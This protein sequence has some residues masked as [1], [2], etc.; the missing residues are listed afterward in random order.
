MTTE[1][2]PVI[3]WILPPGEVAKQRQVALTELARYG[4]TPAQ[5]KFF[6]P[7]LLRSIA[8]IWRKD[9]IEAA[10]YKFDWRKVDLFQQWLDK[11][12]AQHNPK[13]I[14]CNDVGVM[15]TFVDSEAQTAASF[16]GF[17]YRYRGI[18]VVIIDDLR[19]TYIEELSLDVAIELW[20]LRQDLSK[21]IRLGKGTQ[22]R[23]AAFKYDLV[24]SLEQ[25]ETALEALADVHTIGL[26]IETSG[27]WVSSLCLG[28]F[29]PDGSYVSYVWA[30][31]SAEQALDGFRWDVAQETAIWQQLAAF[32]GRKNQTVVCHNGSYD[33]SFLQRVGVTMGGGYVD[34][35][36]MWHAIWAQTKKSLAFCCSIM[37]DDASFWKDEV[38]ED[39]D[40]T[41]A[42]YAVPT[43][44][45]GLKH[46]FQYNALDVYYMVH[47]TMQ[48][49]KVLLDPKRG[50]AALNY[51]K[52]MLNQFGP[53]AYM[54]AIGLRLD[55]SRRMAL[56]DRLGDEAVAGLE[57]LL[58]I[59]GPKFNPSSTPQMRELFYDVLGDV[60]PVKRGPQSTDVKVMERMA[61]VSAMHAYMLGLVKGY[62][63]PVNNS[64]KY[65]DSFRIS[66]NGR[67][68]YS[69]N[70]SATWS[71]RYAGKSNLWNMGTNPQNV[72]KKMR[73][74]CIA[75]EGYVFLDADYG[76]SDLWFVAYEAEDE[77]L[78]ERLNS[79]I[80]IH[81]AHVED[82][83]GVPYEQ[84]VTWR[85]SDD[86][87]KKAFIEHPV[88]GVRQ[89][90]KKVVHGTNYVMMPNTMYATI[91]RPALVAAA[92]SAGH[93]GAAAW[94]NRELVEYCG[95]LQARYFGRY[96]GVFRARAKSIAKCRADGL[97][98]TAYGPR[99]HQFFSDP[100]T[101]HKTGRNLISFFGQAGTAGN[102]N[103]AVMRLYWQT[104]LLDQGVRLHLQVHD[105][106]VHGVPLDKLHLADK[107]YDNMHERCVIKGREFRVPVEADW[108]F[109]W[110]GKSIPYKRGQPEAE[111]RAALAT[112][113]EKS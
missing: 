66:E 53:A 102:I 20:I 63:Q 27:I 39:L 50:W 64:A 96:K 51:R 26:D 83:L 2:A 101:D 111:L 70:I 90:I 97:R 43:T 16:R 21:V 60:R 49:S 24:T 73:G 62:K 36:H 12:I 11:Q 98:A 113:K 35:Q 3:F 94:G 19:K 69:L 92:L 6:Q 80:D 109:V 91:G 17:V 37:L 8:E 103:E 86:P 7:R 89:I 100:Y 65:G 29:K 82:L 42:K 38:K 28:G 85:K 77:V 52:E 44:E 4:T 104:D 88:T 54:N 30:F 84:V 31:A 13:V 74:M 14:V 10:K 75:D 106:L 25:G 108:T 1:G 41:L 59:C 61:E 67:F 93:K 78:I 57:P 18:P 40:D 5:V 48:L 76:Q 107:L 33:L 110:S 87:E 56:L 58:E 71:N 46:Y 9:S 23:S 32:L 68:H 55:N 79:G 112:L 105:N 72:P 99:T 15:P 22:R 34:T 95:Q 81:A 45:Q 47:L